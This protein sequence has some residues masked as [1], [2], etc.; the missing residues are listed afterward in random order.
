[1]SQVMEWSD[2]EEEVQ[3]IIVTP[4]EDEGFMTNCYSGDKD[5]E[6]DINY[7]CRGILSA[8]ATT[9]IELQN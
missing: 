3:E 4:P 1:M 6:G 9:N 5:N 2:D 8:E 7:L